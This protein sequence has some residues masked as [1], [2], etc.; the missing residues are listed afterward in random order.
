MGRIVRSAGMIAEP[1]IGKAAAQAGDAEGDGTEQKGGDGYLQRVAKYI[2]AEVVAFFIF[3]N[4]ILGDAIDKHISDSTP[5]T[6][7]A[8]LSKALSTAKMAGLSVWSISWGAILL[9]FIMTLLYLLAVRDPNDK[10]EH[11]GLN[12][13]VA[14]AAFPVWAYAVDAV[15]FRPW[16]DGAFASIILASFSVVSGAISPN[17]IASIKAAFKHVP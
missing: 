10:Q 4:S 6:Y 16:H 13:L 15:A 17:L 8:Q 12:I 1:Q 3:V 14:L 11:A 2:P 7:P 5:E 9:G